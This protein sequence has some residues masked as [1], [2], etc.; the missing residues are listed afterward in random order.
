MSSLA[1]SYARFS[2][3]PQ[4]EGHSLTRQLEAAEAYATANSLVIDR[5]LS[6][7]DLGVS[8]W[9]RSNIQ[10]GALGLFL[11]AVEGGKVP[12]G[13]TFIVESFDRLSRATPRQALS[14]FTRLLDA[15]LNVVTLNVTPLS[16]K[17][18]SSSCVMMSRRAI[19]LEIST[20]MATSNSPTCGQSNSPGQ[21]GRIMGRQR[22]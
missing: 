13:S 9:D 4:G 16:A 15:G 17:N 8:A 11:K 14:I 7:R 3:A 6:F 2:S 19:W 1:I 20:L 21:D 12:V 18:D 22:R 10:K 5:G